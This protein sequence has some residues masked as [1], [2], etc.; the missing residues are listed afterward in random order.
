MRLMQGIN[1]NERGGRLEGKK[2]IKAVFLGFLISATSFV[3]SEV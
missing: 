2:R 1:E 3:N